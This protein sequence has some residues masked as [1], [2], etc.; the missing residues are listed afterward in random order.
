MSLAVEKLR[1][2]EAFVERAVGEEVVVLSDGDEPAGV[3]DRDAMGVGDGAEPVGDDEG[4]PVFE[5]KVEMPDGSCVRTQ[6]RPGWWL[7]RR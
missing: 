6:R 3:H 7:R 1:F 4:G 2:V 5:E